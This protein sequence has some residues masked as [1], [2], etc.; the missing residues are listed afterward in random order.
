M[1][2]S[3]K[4]KRY[5]KNKQ[6]I[7]SMVSTSRA[8]MDIQRGVNQISRDTI[9]SGRRLQNVQGD[10]TRVRSDVQTRLPNQV[11]TAQRGI[12]DTNQRGLP[13]AE[14]QIDQVLD[15]QRQDEYET[16]LLRR[17]MQ[18]GITEQERCCIESKAQAEE[19][20]NRINVNVRQEANIVM[21]NVT[22][23]VNQRITVEANRTITQINRNYTIILQNRAVIV[24]KVQSVFLQ[25][26]LQITQ[27]FNTVKGLQVVLIQRISQVNQLIINTGNDIKLFIQQQVATIDL[28]IGVVLDAIAA[29]VVTLGE[30]SATVGGL[31]ATITGGFAL[32][33]LDLLRTQAHIDNKTDK[34]G[35]KVVGDL[36]S[37]LNRQSRNIE[38]RLQRIENLLRKLAKNQEE[39]CEELPDRL[40]KI[41]GQY[42]V[43]DSWFRWDGTHTYYPTL[44]F[45]F[46]EKHVIGNAR[47]SQIQIKLKENNKALT[48]ADIIKLRSSV[49]GLGVLEYVYGSNRGYFVAK[50]RRFKTTVYGDSRDDI[51]KVLRACL[52]VVEEDFD[53]DYLSYTNGIK[54]DNIVKRNLPLSGLSV[55]PVNYKKPSVQQL[56]RVLL[57]VNGMEQPIV[58]KE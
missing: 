41:V 37:D 45:K 38:D 40:G 47:T 39:C 43:G 21:T 7:L 16:S 49:R 30:I 32:L 8:I 23:N 14:R 31:T 54:R 51:E 6:H 12:N 1:A 57:L 26:T 35:K 56:F 42:V 33:T 11:R 10:L 27:G 22:N 2:R 25:L 3:R 4:K 44:C 53:P 24:A 5:S 55:N 19:N 17:E 28:T 50:N 18:R 20:V 15:L 52:S 29:V 46:R 58:I 13:Y 34:V 9:A 48:D 36:R